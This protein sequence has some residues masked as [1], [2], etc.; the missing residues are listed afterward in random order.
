MLHPRLQ[1]TLG[2]VVAAFLVKG[3]LATSLAPTPEGLLVL[4]SAPV[5][6]PPWGAFCRT[7]SGSTVERRQC[8][9]L[10]GWGEMVSPMAVSSAPYWG[11]Y[12]GSQA[13]LARPE[14]GVLALG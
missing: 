7:C 1:G 3:S 14:P 12:L 13:P 5:H 8:Q 11:S 10:G 4:N 6:P 9:Y 2:M